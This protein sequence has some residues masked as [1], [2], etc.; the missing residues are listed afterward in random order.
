MKH[1]V[2][3]VKK[4][5]DKYIFDYLILL[6]AGVFFLI[7][8]S[9]FKGDRTIQFIILIAFTCFY[10]MWG[11]YHHIIEDTLHLKTILEYILIGF[12]LLFLLKMI[13]LP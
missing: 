1:L 12:L 10:V 11:I 6:T 13:I 3:H 8:I 9:L 5:L 4:E 2:K 7:G